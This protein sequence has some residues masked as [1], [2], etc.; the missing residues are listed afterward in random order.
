MKRKTFAVVRALAVVVIAAI[1]LTAT[2]ERA[3]GQGYWDFFSVNLT[4]NDLYWNQVNGGAGALSDP[5]VWLDPDGS[6]VFDSATPLGGVA[7]GYGGHDWGTGSLETTAVAGN[8]ISLYGDIMMPWYLS[9]TL[10][11]SSTP[12][13]DTAFPSWGTVS[14]IVVS[15]W[16][17]ENWETFSP[18]WTVSPYSPA[19]GTTQATGSV[20]LAAADVGAAEGDVQSDGIYGIGATLPSALG[21]KVDFDTDLKTWDS[22]VGGGAGQQKVT[23]VHTVSGKEYSNKFD[24]DSAG[25]LDRLQ[26]IAFDGLG[27][28]GDA[29][30][31]TG[32]GLGDFHQLDALANSLDTYYQ[33]VISDQ[34]PMVLS[35]ASPDPQAG[36]IKYQMEQTDINGTWATPTMINAT[37]PPDD[38][39]ALEIWGSDSE[40]NAN[41]F[42]LTDDI[43]GVAVYKYDSDLHTATEYI[44]SDALKAAI[45]TTEQIDLDAMMVMDAIGEEEDEFAS[46]DSIMFSIRET[47][48]DDGAFD[49]GEIWVWNFDYGTAVFLTHGGE[50][51]DTAHTVGL[52]FGVGTEEVN[53]LEALSVPEPISGDVN[54]DGFIDDNDLTII[55]DNWGQSGLGWSGGDLNGNGVVDGPDYAEVLSYW[56][57]PFE[58]PGEPTPEPATL[59]LLLVG[60]WLV[61]GRRARL[62][63][64]FLC[65]G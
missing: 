53:A 55:L 28:A 38:V 57:P 58:P 30:D 64:I 44:S 62:W 26:N 18:T 65:R 39:D 15:Q 48:S 21:Y 29:F 49:G 61:L 16:D 42:S 52:D 31:Y 56:N 12:N 33:E 63:R 6:P 24:E 22:Y 20:T 11:S 8:S 36:D 60:S 47:L 35:F 50:I 59:G 34:V 7:Y 37:S 5:L 14:N 45:G 13:A 4:P 19:G 41:M 10:D 54:G 1:V 43:M 9:I 17:G 25:M 46:G 23:P 3:I 27:N 51:W 32:S 40:D 2:A